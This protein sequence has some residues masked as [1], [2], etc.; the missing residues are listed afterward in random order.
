MVLNKSHLADR[1][2]GVGAR[3][4]GGR[5]GSLGLGLE[6]RVKL[7]ELAAQRLALLLARGHDRLEMGVALATLAAARVPHRGRRTTTLLPLC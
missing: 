6:A 3:L 4:R 5:G 1:A 2:A 7:R